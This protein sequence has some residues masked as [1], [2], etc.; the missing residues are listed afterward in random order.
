[1]F[2]CSCR[3]SMAQSVL[4]RQCFLSAHALLGPV[5]DPSSTLST[6]Q[7]GDFLSFSLFSVFGEPRERRPTTCL[8][9][10][11]VLAFSPAAA[12]YTLGVDLFR[13]LLFP[14][15]L[16]SSSV[17]RASTTVNWIKEEPKSFRWV[18]K[19]SRFLSQSTNYVK[20]TFPKDML[21]EMKR[22][23]LVSL[24]TW[25]GREGKNEEIDF[26]FSSP[27]GSQLAAFSWAWRRLL[28]SSILPAK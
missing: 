5:F 28:C 27:F 26:F 17:Y 16:N 7:G 22:A 21:R 3:V 24:V 12:R 4:C 25:W 14:P 15:G 9:V 11:D 8:A 2:N 23:V 1:M 13:L 18:M 20:P 10:A 19:P 6:H